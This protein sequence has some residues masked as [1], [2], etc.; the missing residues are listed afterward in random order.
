MKCHSST[1]LKNNDDYFSRRSTFDIISTILITAKQGETKTRIMYTCNLNYEQL[2]YYIQFLLK[3]EFLDKQ[4]STDK[5][6]KTLKSTP[7]GLKF[8]R[9]YTEI[10]TLMNLDSTRD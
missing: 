1:T 8:L 6:K 9:K 2:K 7:K 4:L 5:K 3:M 10:Q